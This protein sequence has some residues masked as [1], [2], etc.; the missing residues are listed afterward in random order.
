[1]PRLGLTDVIVAL[2]WLSGVVMGVEDASG[3]PLRDR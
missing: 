2:P 1:M 3:T